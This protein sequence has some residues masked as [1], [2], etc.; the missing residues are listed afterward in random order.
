MNT[1]KGQWA[2]LDMYRPAKDF[3]SSSNI[4]VEF[5]H[6]QNPSRDKND[7]KKEQSDYKLNSAKQSGLYKSIKDKGIQKPVFL[8]HSK[9]FGEM[10]S[11]G[12]HRLSVANDLGPNT[13]VPVEHG[14]DVI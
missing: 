1:D 4:D 8:T 13:I 10:V 12:G 7:I 6:M 3:A 9:Q 2:Q 14:E 11:D 5:E